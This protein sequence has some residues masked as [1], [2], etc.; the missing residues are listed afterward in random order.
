M[1]TNA[2]L[3]LASNDQE[4]ALALWR[5]ARV[6]ELRKLFLSARDSYLD[7]MTRYPHARVPDARGRQTVAEVVTAELWRGLPIRR[8]KAIDPNR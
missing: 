2:C 8:L 4:C 5:L 3:S 1:F 6:Y 7:L